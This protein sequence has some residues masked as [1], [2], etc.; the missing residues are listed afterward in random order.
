MRFLGIHWEQLNVAR[1]GA[2]FLY[3]TSVSAVNIV[4]ESCL[5]RTLD[6]RNSLPWRS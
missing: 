1:G 2:L 4:S 6:W 3:I 5:E